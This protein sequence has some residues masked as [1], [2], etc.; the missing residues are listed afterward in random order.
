MRASSSRGSIPHYE[1]GGVLAPVTT[2]GKKQ[3]DARSGFPPYWR[4][5]SALM[6]RRAL[7]TRATLTPKT[8]RWKMRKP[9][10]GKL[11]RPGARS[12]SGAARPQ[13]LG[14]FSHPAVQAVDKAGDD[15]R[16]RATAGLR[17]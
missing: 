2:L 11:R 1:V 5:N 7:S 15:L 14:E 16:P 10:T 3:P 9:P 13:Q 4:S 12:P 6:S 8:L 17:E